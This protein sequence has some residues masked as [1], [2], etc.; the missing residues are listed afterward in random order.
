MDKACHLNLYCEVLRMV[1]MVVG[2]KRRGWNA[3]VF[4]AALLLACVAQAETKKAPPNPGPAADAGPAPVA[5]IAVGPLGFLAPSPAYLDSRIAWASLNFIDD[6]QLLFTFHVNRLMKRIP[7]EPVEDDDQVIHTEVLEIASGKVL[8]Q[9]DWRMHDR[10]RYLWA[11]KDGQFLVRERNSLFLT[12]S[13]LALTPYLTFDSDLQAV[14]ISPGRGLMLL[15]VKI[16]LAPEEAA[17]EGDSGGVAPSLLG[18]ERVKRTRTEML[19]LRPGTKTVLAHGV[20]REPVQVPLLEDGFLNVIEGKTSKQ[21]VIEEDGIDN[22]T[23]EIAEVRSACAPQMATLSGNVALAANCPL[24]GGNGSAMSA[25]S[26]TGQVLWQGLWQARYIWPSF[27]LAENGR[28]FAYESLETNRDIG[29]IDSFGEADV[30]AQPVGVFDTETGKLELVRTASPILS[31]GQNFALSA[32]GRRFAILR[33]GA[34][35]VYDLPPAPAKEPEKTGESA[36][37]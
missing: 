27:E 31:E 3:A 11:L 4:A 30:V 26:L 9:A 14:E 16:V 13:D 20:M 29:A 22:T 18:A 24:N 17:G 34:I 1:L 12:G 21:W 19:I 25:L 2:S 6:K 35:E 10:G 33:D 37:K 15:E 7:D 23:R 8:R 28:R 5:R 32:D 36:K